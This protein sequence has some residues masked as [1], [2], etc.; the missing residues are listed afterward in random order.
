MRNTGRGRRAVLFGNLHRKGDVHLMQLI[1]YLITTL[2]LEVM[3]SGYLQVY[4][5]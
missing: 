5:C 1:S 4:V 3:L 2:R